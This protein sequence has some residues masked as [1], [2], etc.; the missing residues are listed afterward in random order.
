MPKFGSRSKKNLKGVKSELINVLNKVVKD[1]D[2]T[3]TE[4]L[5]SGERQQELYAQGRSK[6][7][8]VNRKSKHQ[9]GMAVDIAPYPIDYSDTKGFYY[10][11]G[12]MMATAKRL[13]V[14]IRWGGDWNMDQKF[15]GHPDHPRTDESQ[16][17]DDLVHYELRS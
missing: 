7:D 12:I 1:Y 15:S 16:K 2:I 4:G 3:V 10:L 11:A 5:R 8:G 6:L 17:F 14:R 9:T 13:G